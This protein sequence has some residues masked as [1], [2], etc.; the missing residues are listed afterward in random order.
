M[1][2]CQTCEIAIPEGSSRCPACG[3]NLHLGAWL[4]A[5]GLMVLLALLAGLLWGS[6]WIKNRVDRAEV[7]LEEVRAVAEKLVASSPDVHNPVGF[8]GGEQTTV[9][10]WDGRRWRVSGYVDTK[11]QGGGKVRTLY[12]AVVQYNGAGWNLEDLQLQSME[13]QAPRRGKTD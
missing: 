11:P 7:P 10:H 5:G 6:G 13:L 3:R 2:Y 4:I 1:L 12:F 9:E 8:S